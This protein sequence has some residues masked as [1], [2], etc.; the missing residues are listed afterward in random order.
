MKIGVINTGGTFS[1]A[2]TDM[3]L[4]PIPLAEKLIEIGKTSGDDVELIAEDL[5]SMD[6]SNIMPGDWVM[7]ANRIYEFANDLDGI[8]IIHGTDTMAYTASMLSFMVENPPIPIVFTGSQ[9]PLGVNMSDGH[10]NFQCALEMA[11]SGYRGIFV[12]FNYSIILGVRSS[13]V[14]SMGFRAFESI[15]YPDA[16]TINALGLQ[17]NEKLIPDYS[18]DFSLKTNYSDKIAILRIFPGMKGDIFLFLR[19]RGYEGIFIEGFGLGGVPFM[20][21]DLLEGIEVASNEGIP[22]LVGSQCRYDGSN[23]NIYEVGRH[24]LESGGIPVYDMTK[25][26]VITKL[27]HCLGYTKDRIEITKRFQT[28]YVNEVTLPKQEHNTLHEI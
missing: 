27:M 19:E 8:I 10:T 20:R 2:P 15:N 6:S 3:G 12:A 13:K 23:L 28:N 22:I 1:C 4:A 17:I 24:V 5:C 21:S 11:K 26:S 25:E 14:R 7:I 9:L 16:G 18:N